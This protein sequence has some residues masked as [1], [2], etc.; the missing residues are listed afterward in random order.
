MNLGKW[1]ILFWIAPRSWLCNWGYY[2]NTR[3][4]VFF[5]VNILFIEVRYFGA[6][7][8][9]KVCKKCGKEE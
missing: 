2:P 6:Y 8:Q 7:N 3:D 5:F 4:P 9:K 1:E